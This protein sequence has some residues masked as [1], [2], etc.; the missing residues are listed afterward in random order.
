MAK[1]KRRRR[2]SGL[3]GMAS[4]RCAGLH[5]SGRKKGKLKKN[6]KWVRGKHCPVKVR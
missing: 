6:Y 5:S 2:K 3:S 4:T 1:K